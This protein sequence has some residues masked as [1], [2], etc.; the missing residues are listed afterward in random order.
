M[1]T[2]STALLEELRQRAKSVRRHIV[3][4]VA[5]AGSGHPAGSLSATDLMVT[6]YFHQLRHRPEDPA[7]PDRDRFILSKGH[8]APVLY[9][10]LAEA[11][12][13]SKDLLLTLRRPDSPLQGHPELGKPPGVEMTTGSLGQGFSVAI[14]LALAAKLD[15]KPW[16]VYVMLGDGESQEGQVW[17][18][19]MFAAYHKVD[20]LTAILDRNHMQ[21][22]GHMEEILE[23]EPVAEKWR[24]FGWHVVQIDGHDFVQIL[25][26]FAEAREVRGKPTI[27]VAETVKGKGVSFMEGNPD[28]HGK[29]P[30]K[31]QLAQALAE[32]A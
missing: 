13:F 1:G 18:A 10:T 17:E 29:A 7:W 6:L 27:I 31:E 16:R 19:A 30:S 14:G 11:G 9:A 20:N 28:F 21:N 25:D 26:A 5:A 22:D 4:M 15:K 2:Y 8:C 24:A 32:L 3:T 12:Y 23:I